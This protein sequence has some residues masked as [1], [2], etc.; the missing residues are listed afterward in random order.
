MPPRAGG[1]RSGCIRFLATGVALAA[2]ALAGGCAS[3]EPAAQA[4][5]DEVLAARGSAPAVSLAE[6]PDSP[7]TRAAVE[8][9]LAEPL[10]PERAARI[11]LIANRR[12]RVALA[13]ASFA[14]ADLW[15]AERLPNPDFSATMRWPAGGGPATS[16]LSAGFDVLDGLLIPLRKRLAGEALNAAERR[17]AH[18]ALGLVAQVETAC[19]VLAAREEWRARLAVLHGEDEAR[20]RRA[21]ARGGR[22][23]GAA[24]ARAQAAETGAELAQVD[25][26][27]V[28]DRER[29]NQLMGLDGP[30]SRWRLAGRAAPVPA[31]PPDARAAEAAALSTR[32]DLAADRVDVALM[33]QACELKRRTRLL[34]VGVKLGVESE[35][36]SSGQRLTGPTVQLG[37]PIFD[38]GQA[39][40]LRLE[41]ALAQAEDRAAACETDIRSEARGAVAL[42]GASRRLAL[43][44]RDDCLAEARRLWEQSSRNGGAGPLALRWAR[45]ELVMAERQEI[46][47][48][49]DYWLARVSLARAIGGSPGAAGPCT[50]PAGGAAAGMDIGKP[51][52]A[53]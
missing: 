33:R 31:E 8:A 53:S 52:P 42:V 51:R 35:K 9:L 22:P 38:Q 19:L 5:V 29:L 24:Q 27:L 16:T 37:V 39:D 28:L 49:R 46:E 17:A 1:K 26:Q 6:R 14:E 45:R 43:T 12:L 2:A 7:R 25:A 10:T 21:A 50:R 41:T 48:R 34:P 30:P 40:L 23:L 15:Q 20:S 4:G 36:E 44:R 11:A 3:M 32:L 18:E 47:A 13:A